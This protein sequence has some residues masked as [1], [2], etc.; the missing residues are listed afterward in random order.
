MKQTSNYCIKYFF[1]KTHLSLHEDVID[2]YS[3]WV[4]LRKGTKNR[5]S[6]GPESYPREAAKE[7]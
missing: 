3:L 1:D 4:S 7:E 6:T 5:E 2:D